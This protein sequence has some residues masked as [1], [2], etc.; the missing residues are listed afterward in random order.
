MTL[1]VRRMLQRMLPA[2]E[3]QRS[4]SVDRQRCHS[5]TTTA[6]TTT[7]PHVALQVVVPLRSVLFPALTADRR[8]SL[9]TVLAAAALAAA[10]AAAR[11]L[12]DAVAAEQRRCK[13]TVTWS[14]RIRCTNVE[15][16]RRPTAAFVSIATSRFRGDN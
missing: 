8:M 5:S 4:S 11:A 10:A 12:L 16:G 9:L 14:V 6:A 3:W 15:V 2:A 13:C 1:I 7:T